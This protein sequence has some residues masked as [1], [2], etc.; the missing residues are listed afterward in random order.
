ALRS[1]NFDV[2]CSPLNPALGLDARWHDWYATGCNALIESVAIFVAVE[3]DGYECSTWM[4]HEADTACK[5]ARGHERPML[6]YLARPSGRRLS[7][8][9]RR[10]E[11]AAVKLPVDPTEAVQAIL[12]DEARWGANLAR[13]FKVGG[14]VDETEVSLAVYG[15]DLDPTAV[16]T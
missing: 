12:A 8:G 11:D 5:V 10:F 7:I 14:M 3:T 1:A 9:F 13:T 16:T 6:Y 15:E 2:T 4:A